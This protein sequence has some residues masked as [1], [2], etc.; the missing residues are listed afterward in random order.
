VQGLDHLDGLEVD[1]E[2]LRMA[3]GSIA[4]WA[5]HEGTT[6]GISVMPDGGAILMATYPDL[7]AARHAAR[8][9]RAFR[10]LWDQSA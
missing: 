6:L 1:F 5:E 7:E 8:Q 3:D 10:E 4:A 2:G 9:A